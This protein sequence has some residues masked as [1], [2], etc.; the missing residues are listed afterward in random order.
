MIPETTKRKRGK[1]GRL[2]LFGLG[3]GLLGFVVS[4]LYIQFGST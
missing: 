1:A 3:G 4:M 2:A